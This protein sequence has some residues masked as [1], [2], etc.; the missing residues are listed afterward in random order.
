[1]DL[2][3]GSAYESIIL[4]DSICAAV[5]LQP[6][7]SGGVFNPDSS[8]TLDDTSIQYSDTNKGFNIDWTKGALRIG[9]RAHFATDWLTLRAVAGGSKTI[10]N[11]AVRL[12]YEAFMTYPDGTKYPLQVGQLALGMATV[13]Q[14]FDRGAGLPPVNASLVSGYLWANKQIPSSSYGLHIGSAILGP[15]LSLWMG[16]YDQSRVIGPVSSQSCNGEGRFTI[17]LLDIAI[18]VDQGASPFPYR[19]RENILAEKNSSMPNSLGVDINPAGPYLVLPESTCAA[20]ARDLPVTFNN[21]YGLYVW[22]VDD[23]QYN[24]II[25]SPS[26][27]AF[28]FRASGI[29]N[30]NLTI[31]VPFQL[32]NLTLEAPL[33]QEPTS[34]LPCWPLQLSNPNSQYSLGRAFLQAAFFGVNWNQGIG[35][36]FLA[37]APGPNTRSTPDT[38]LY[39]SAFSESSSGSDEWSDSWSGYWKPLPE[40]TKSSDGRT[41]SATQSIEISKTASTSGPAKIGL[42]LGIG[43]AA[44]VSIAIAALFCIHRHRRERREMKGLPAVVQ[45]EEPRQEQP[46]VIHEAPDQEPRELDIQTTLAHELHGNGI[47]ELSVCRN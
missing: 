27:L 45:D 2:Y 36:W 5:I 37:Q 33:V 43:I 13:N 41:P 25:T 20:I 24:E 32:L 47:V 31:K 46:D 14:T 6:C 28:I 16:G 30:A 35:K 26:Y 42:G 19:V 44:L 23:P 7:G 34:Y 15:P 17:D 21:R 22:N 39:S 11:A 29:S 1:M 8:S 4:T 38:A 9:G 3:P 10:T 40:T 18:G 12:I